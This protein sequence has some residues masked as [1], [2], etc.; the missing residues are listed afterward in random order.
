MSA[1]MRHMTM[2]YDFTS[3][4]HRCWKSGLVYNVMTHLILLA[5]PD[6]QVQEAEEAWR[7]EGSAR[8]GFKVFRRNERRERPHQGASLDASL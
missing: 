7:V 4:K 1:D 6:P 3:L 8:A 2:S 5:V